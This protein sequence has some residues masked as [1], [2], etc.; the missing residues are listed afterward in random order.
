MYYNIKE[1]ITH[2]LGDTK[3]HIIQMSWLKK[4]QTKALQFLDN[5]FII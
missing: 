4:N 3:T 2:L 1:I 5:V